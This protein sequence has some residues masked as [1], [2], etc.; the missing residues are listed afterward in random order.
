MGVAC[1]IIA[2]SGIILGTAIVE[3]IPM[4]DANPSDR[5]AAKEIMI[6]YLAA[7]GSSAE[8]LFRKEASQ[9]PANKNFAETWEAILKTVS[10]HN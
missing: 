10:D 7:L 8:L 1:P 5:Q 9:A 6:A 4:I 2:P 3:E